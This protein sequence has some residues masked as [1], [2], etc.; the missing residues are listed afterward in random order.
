VQRKKVAVLATQRLG[1]DL[2]QAGWAAM[3]SVE[4]AQKRRNEVIHQ[5]WLLLGCEAMRSVTEFVAVADEDMGGY[6]EDWQRQATE[7]S[8]W[9]RVPA[10]R[11]T[12]CQPKPWRLRAVERELA[13]VTATVSELVFAV[14]SSR[15]TGNRR[16]TF[17]P[18]QRPDQLARASPQPNRR[19]KSQTAIRPS[20]GRSGVG[21]AGRS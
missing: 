21:M 5:D 4:A 1:G 12:W 9:Q 20:S 13:A 11:Y 8:N 14:A 18:T 16:V 10:T 6:L 3:S 15:E 7:S 19:R 17:T 2:Q